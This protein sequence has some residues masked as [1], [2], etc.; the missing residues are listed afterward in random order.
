MAGTRFL[1]LLLGEFIAEK[2]KDK[3]CKKLLFLIFLK[4][5]QKCCL[6]MI[7]APRWGATDRSIF[8]VSL[9]LGE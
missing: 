2:Q 5:I 1:L 4:S 9:S 7:F 3:A 8:T 6:L